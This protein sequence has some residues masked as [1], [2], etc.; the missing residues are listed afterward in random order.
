MDSDMVMVLTVDLLM[1]FVGTV[2]LGGDTFGFIVRHSNR[3]L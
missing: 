1:L 3:Q 2:G